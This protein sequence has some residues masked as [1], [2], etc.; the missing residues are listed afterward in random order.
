ME[1]ALNLDIQ[2]QV[3]L[4]SGA[5]NGIGRAIAEYLAQEGC[6]VAVLDR[7]GSAAQ[8]VAA[9]IESRAGRAIALAVDV[10]DSCSVAEAVRATSEKLGGLHIV[11][12]N[13]GF[14]MDAPVDSMSDEQWHKVLD[15]TLTGAFHCVRH[16]V[17]LLKA[18]GY[19]RIINMASRA[20]FGDVNKTNYSSA[21]AGLIGMTKSLSLELGP[22]GV[23]VNAVA[24]GIIETPRLRALPYLAGIEERSKAAMPIKRF[25]TVD[26]VA[27]LVAFLAST[28]SGFISGEVVHI[29]GGRYG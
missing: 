19:G 3:A 13:A 27:R 9:G 20:H 29:S 14:S 17:P 11:V 10:T 21:K 2:D 6:R 15:V 5:G 4:V 8:D 18:Q 25:G 7:D 23:T 26:E 22:L 1:D 24:P 12:N 16:A 28:H